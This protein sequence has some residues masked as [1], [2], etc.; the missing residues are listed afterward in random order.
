MDIV[1]KV[2]GII[3]P[4]AAGFV[5]RSSGVFHEDDAAVLRRFVVR[6]A[7]PVL[8]FY[9]MYDAGRDEVAALPVMLAG[10]V[11]V[12]GARFVLGY[13]LSFTASGGPRKTAVHAST[14]FG[15]Y[16]WLGFGVMHVLLGDEGLRR[17]VFFV[18]LWWPVFFGFGLPA[19]I[20]HNGREKDGFNLPEA[21][22]LM[23]PVATGLAAGIVMH[24]LKA[25]LPGFLDLTLRPF[26]AA[27]VP[28]IL[29]SAGMSLRIKGILP[30]LLPALYISVAVLCVAPA[31]G[32]VIAR[33]LTD[34]PVSRA[35]IVL[36]AAMPTATLTPVLG[37]Y[38]K[39]DS[40]TANTAV[41]VSTLLSAVTLPLVALLVV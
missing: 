12:T 32:W 11:L 39:L 6:V 13:I 35:V 24:S 19:G 34:D 8:V 33:A 10:I 26:A 1:L 14:A 30:S 9:S 29:F 2:L 27:V 5:F 38:V 28:L 4:I 23:V 31:A 37:E 22:K 7:L 16:G 36:E 40:N 15:N 41:V 18:L 21:V 17:A 25:S 3:L 20:I